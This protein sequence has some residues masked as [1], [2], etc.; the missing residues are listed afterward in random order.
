MEYVL[1]FANGPVKNV[2]VQRNPRTALRVNRKEHHERTSPRANPGQSGTAEEGVAVS[3][4]VAC[5]AHLINGLRDEHGPK[6]CQT[7]SQA[8]KLGLALVAAIPEPG[9]ETEA[10]R[11]LVF[12]ELLTGNL[13]YWIWNTNDAGVPLSALARAALET[14]G[15]PD[16]FT[17]LVASQSPLYG[18]A[19]AVR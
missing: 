8:S 1:V 15:G 12:L 13:E 11:L 7:R 5:Y 6:P 16:D 2:P 17:W 18:F 4:P 3:D 19:L 9:T 10:D 14:Y